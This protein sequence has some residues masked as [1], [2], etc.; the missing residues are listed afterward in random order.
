M[1]LRSNGLTINGRP[2]WDPLLVFCRLK[3]MAE[4]TA[5]CPLN[6]RDVP[7]GYKSCMP[8][9]VREGNKGDYAAGRPSPPPVPSAAEITLRDR[10]VEWLAFVEKIDRVILWGYAVG[11]SSRAIEAQ[12]A[13]LKVRLSY[14]TIQQRFPQLLDQVAMH[15]QRRGH[16][17]DT[18]SA[19]SAAL[20]VERM[21]VALQRTPRAQGITYFRPERA[22][23][24]PVGDSRVVMVDMPMPQYRRG[25]HKRASQ[26]SQ[27]RA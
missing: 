10:T 14:R 1:R 20:A 5:R 12:L 21:A 7:G 22:A 9:P 13:R 8:E 3:L 26:P 24:N 27:I 25:V 16:E 4:I 2:A 6:S 19:F 18:G 17:V 23:Y 11:Q 15:W